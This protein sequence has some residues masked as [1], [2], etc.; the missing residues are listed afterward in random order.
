MD[1]HSDTIRRYPLAIAHLWDAF[2]LVV[3]PLKCLNCGS[4]FQPGRDRISAW[5]HKQPKKP[6]A[7]DYVDK[8][9]DRDN[10]RTISP[11]SLFK[12]VMAGHICPSCAQEFAPIESPCC[13]YCGIMFTSREGSDH[14]CGE[15]LEIKRHFSMARSVGVYDQALMSV[16][17]HFKYR[18]RVNL[19]KPLSFLLLHT[20][21]RFWHEHPMDM[22]IPVPLY[23]HRYRQ[24]GFNQVYLALRTWGTPD[25]QQ[26]LPKPME[27]SGN[28]L[29]R[30]RRTS[31]QTGLGRQDRKRNVSKAFRS[32]KMDTVR[33]KKILL[34]DDVYTTG[35][36]VNECARILMQAGAERVDVL[37]IARAI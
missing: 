35:A 1:M 3:F 34:V 21:C 37:T 33:N 28:A 29:Q 30:I 23:R 15:C 32:K 20:Y 4:P 22:V 19:A 26:V 24:R 27:I 12:N 7:C 17:H 16:I 8:I 6:A 25:W 2:K 9:I 13:V 11:S 14:V 31:P 10:F 18:H 5:N 36:T